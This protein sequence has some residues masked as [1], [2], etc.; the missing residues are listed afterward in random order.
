[1]TTQLKFPALTLFVAGLMLGTGSLFGQQTPD[2]LPEGFDAA[3][4]QL[5]ERD[6]IEIIVYDEPDLSISQRID[7]R[8]Q[9]RVPLL[10]TTRIA[11]KTV[12]EAEKLLET[13]YV[14]RRILRDPMVTIRVSEYA[15]KEVSVLGAVA[16]PGRVALPIEAGSLDI[17]EVISNV[18]GFT[19]IARSDRVRVSRRAANGREQTFTVNVERMISGGGRRDRF[20]SSQRQFEVLPGDIIYVDERL[21]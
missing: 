7:G 3:N 8:G 11:G 15:P 9:V 20:Q 21:F 13:S 2:S 16:N 19:G 14:D 4:Y 10:G 5:S 12:R 6:Q 18:G 17:V 1:M